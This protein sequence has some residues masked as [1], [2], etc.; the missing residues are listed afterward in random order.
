MGDIRWES[1][2]LYKIR[3]KKIKKEDDKDEAE[4]GNNGKDTDGNQCH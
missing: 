2:Q 1:E 3:K 4:E